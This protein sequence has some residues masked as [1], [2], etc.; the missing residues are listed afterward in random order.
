[1][2]PSRKSISSYFSTAFCGLFLYA[3]FF[4]LSDV[5]AQPTFAN[6][7]AGTEFLLVFM[8]NENSGYDPSSTR[9]QDIF[10]T[11]KRYLCVH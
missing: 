2:Y 11:H 10:L 8:A 4:N 9:Y 5:K 3:I 1:M 6:T 7:D